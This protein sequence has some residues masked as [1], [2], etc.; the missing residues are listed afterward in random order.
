VSR[1]IGAQLERCGIH[2]TPHQL[3]HTFGTEFA[4]HSN[5]NLIAL[6]AVMGHETTNT[7]MGYVGW[8]SR[9]AKVIAAMYQTPAG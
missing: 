3:R 5:G 8:S 7:T 1:T 9:S 2:A 6:A 4:R